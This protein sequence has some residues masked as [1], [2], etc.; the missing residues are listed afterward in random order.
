M[1][2]LSSKLGNKK[3][4]NRSIWM[5]RKIGTSRNLVFRVLCLKSSIAARA[6][7]GPK[8]AINKSLDSGILR[9]P[10]LL[11]NL[12]IPKITRGIPFMMIRRIC[13]KKV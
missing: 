1:L 9:P 10:F 6:P 5:N 7:N 4:T 8:K 12:S 13:R 2:R 11:F 3:Y